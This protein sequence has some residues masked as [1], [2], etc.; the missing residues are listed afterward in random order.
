MLA[1]LV[2]QRQLSQK[3]NQDLI[4]DHIFHVAKEGLSTNLYLKFLTSLSPSNM[5]AGFK[6]SDLYPFNLDIVLDQLEHFLESPSLPSSPAAQYPKTPSNTYEIN[7]QATTITT[8]LERHLSS[9]QTPIF[10]AL[11]QLLRGAQKIATSV[12]LLQSQFST[13]QKVRIGHVG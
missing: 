5:K 8:R 12:A 9:S 1:V 2:L 6:S 13:I 11:G 3:N 7:Q 4:R 10:E